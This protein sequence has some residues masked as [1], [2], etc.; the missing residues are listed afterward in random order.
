MVIQNTNAFDKIIF[1][2]A[3][4]KDMYSNDFFK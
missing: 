3:V 4:V 2:K 1:S